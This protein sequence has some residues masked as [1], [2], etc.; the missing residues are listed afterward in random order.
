M[1]SSQIRP[2]KKRHSLYIYACLAWPYWGLPEPRRSHWMMSANFW[3]L[4]PGGG[5]GGEAGSG[6]KGSGEFATDSSNGLGVDMEYLLALINNWQEGTAPGP[7]PGS[8]HAQPETT[9]A[10]F[11]LLCRGGGCWRARWRPGPAASVTFRTDG[12]VAPVHCFPF[13]QPRPCPVALSFIKT[14]RFN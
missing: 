11:M 6:H 13:C 5:G 3:L 10:P 7:F 2:L 12:T 14:E 4:S 9:K 8:W 1:G